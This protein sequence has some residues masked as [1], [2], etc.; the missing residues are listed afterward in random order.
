MCLSAGAPRSLLF[1]RPCGHPGF[2]FAGER[3][4]KQKSR[5]ARFGRSGGRQPGRSIVTIS[6]A[7]RTGRLESPARLRFEG[8]QVK[9]CGSL[10]V[11]PGRPRILPLLWGSFALPQR[12]LFV[13]SQPERDGKVDA[14]SLPCPVPRLGAE[15]R[16][17]RS[18][19]RRIPKALTFG[20][21]RQ[22]PTVS[23]PAVS[24]N[25]ATDL[26]TPVNDRSGLRR[27]AERKQRPCRQTCAHLEHFAS[28][29]RRNRQV[30][31]LTG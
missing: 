16:L 29:L 4:G 12:S 10:P 28:E 11:G 14:F 19:Q 8:R 17:G 7:D 15:L 20:R 30:V 31:A 22:H 25:R 18:P 13:R 3:R 24:L 1:G 9:G 27:R 6:M 23:Q 5:N 21:F 2:D 26:R